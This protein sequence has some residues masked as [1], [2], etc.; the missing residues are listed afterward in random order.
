MIDEEEKERIILCDWQNV[1]VG[2]AVD[3]LSFFISRANA[4]GMQLEKNTFLEKYCKLYSSKTGITV[5]LEE[6]LHEMAISE[7]LVSFQFWHHYLHNSD[8]ARVA[9]VFN[10]MIEAFRDIQYKL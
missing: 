5:R 8:R 3:D 1:L 4:D 2:H 10:Q 6:I 9:T 7:V